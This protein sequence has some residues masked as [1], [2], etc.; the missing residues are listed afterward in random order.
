MCNA[1]ESTL[2]SYYT[3]V[4][5]DGETIVMCFEVLKVP[6]QLSLL[7]FEQSNLVLL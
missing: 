6:T 2:I 1:P 5:L 7:C 4:L 3:S